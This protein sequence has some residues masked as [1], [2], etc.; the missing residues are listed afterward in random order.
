MTLGKPRQMDRATLQKVIGAFEAYYRGEFHKT[1][2]AAA[3]V[4]TDDLDNWLGWYIAGAS[5]ARINEH[6]EAIWM[7]ER[8]LA[9][10][11]KPVP[12]E[13][14][15]LESLIRYN[16]GRLY[17]LNGDIHRAVTHY[18]R[19]LEL[20]DS[21][22]SAWSNLG[23]AY[24]ELN[25]PLDA[26]RA[27]RRAVKCSPTSAQAKYNRAFPSL[28]MGDWATGLDDY[29]ARWEMIEHLDKFS[30][31]DITTRLWDGVPTYETL[32]LHAEQGRGDQL[33]IFRYLPRLQ[34]MVG[35]LI[36]ETFDEFV[37]LLRASFPGIEV[38]TR[39][40]VVK[41]WLNDGAMRTEQAP[42]PPTHDVNLPTMS[43]L[44]TLGERVGLLDGRPYLTAPTSGPELPPTDQLRVGISWAG[45]AAFLDDRK[46][47]TCI[48]QWAPVFAIPGIEWVSLLV[49]D[50]EAELKAAPVPVLRSAAIGVQDFADSA[51]VMRQCDLVITVDTATV[52]LA[53]ALGVPTWLLLPPVPDWR[54]LLERED[55]PWYDSV[56]L[57]R[58]RKAASW[59]DVLLRVAKALRAHLANRQAKEQ[60]A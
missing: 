57:F 28:V 55:T 1:T 12:K 52:H 30:R 4:L 16:L 19:S 46:R 41:S 6:G 31:P 54:W 10:M 35:H 24:L 40:D 53:G 20:N 17:Q 27:H 43:L 7:L 18:R 26:M 48:E 38:V 2:R 33:M 9:T 8:A 5:A 42:P 39:N 50:R 21:Q 29:E 58:Q 47:S 59:D 51:Y 56:R 32:Y 23:N 44:Y 3:E 14:E 49:G 13:S 36:V 11:P 37:P 45:S 25:Q 22:P 15:N 60:A 34:G